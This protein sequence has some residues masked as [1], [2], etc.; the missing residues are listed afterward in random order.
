M[1]LHFEP[2]LAENFHGTS[3]AGVA[4]AAMNS[5]CGVGAAFQA[6]GAGVRL[7]GGNSDAATEA[8][9]MTRKFVSLPS[10]IL[11]FVV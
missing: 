2:D 9:G 4:I 7:I 6:S 1:N 5:V 10:L 8:A 3:A 11:T